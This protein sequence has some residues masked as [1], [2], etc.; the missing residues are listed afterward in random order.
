MAEQ[1]RSGRLQPVARLAEDKQQRAARKLGE[2]R[3]RLQQQQQQLQELESYRNEYICQLQ[4][5]ARNGIKATQ[6]RHY[7]SFVSKLSEAIEQQQ[8]V[9]LVAE[10]DVAIAQDNWF[11]TRN[12]VKMVGSV[13]SSCQ[14]EELQ[15]ELRCEQKESDE[16]A[17]RSSG[18]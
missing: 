8:K 5:A 3:Q 15:G 14:A 6:L 11:Q 10:Q 17:Q 9:V 12:R 4:D 2:I 13:I 7:Q 1:K 16:C 18:G